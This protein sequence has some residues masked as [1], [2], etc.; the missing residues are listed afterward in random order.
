[1]IAKCYNF[2]FEK[3]ALM[4]ATLFE[5]GVK[6]TTKCDLEKHENFGGFSSSR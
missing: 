4:V 1:M 2:D 3:N 5:M 6:T